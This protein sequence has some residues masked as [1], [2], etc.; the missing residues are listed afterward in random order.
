[1]SSRRITVFTA[2]Y[3][4]AYTIEQLYRS[5]QRQ[6]FRDFEWVVI[7][8]GSSDGTEELFQSFLQEQNS[9]DV[10]YEKVENGG[11]HRA[12]NRGLQKACGELFWIV[13]SDDYLVD[14]ALERID[15][16][17]KTLTD[18]QRKTFAGVCAQKGYTEQISVGMTFHGS[19]YLDI[20]SLDFAKHSVTGD[21]AEV[22]YTALLKKY[23]FP[24]FEGERFLTEAIVWDRIAA[25][26]HQLRLF[27]DILY[28]CEYL[29]DG[30]SVN[31]SSH[32]QKAPKGYALYIV[33]SVQYGKL[34]GL[35][36]WQTRQSYYQQF[37]HDLKYSEISKLLEL[38]PVSFRLRLFG[39]KLIY[40]CHRV[41]YR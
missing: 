28:I 21:K 32:F 34:A 27:N 11:K 26:G 5:L 1:M 31:C 25:D 41:F 8:D 19:E 9:F 15:A 16:V 13:D 40:I 36:K 17:E 33:Q 24:E 38:N 4:R 29:E 18:E 2:T 14:T 6:T 23:P 3:N 39:L 22:F 10:I 12:I 35:K 7:D 37:K 30:L 20:T